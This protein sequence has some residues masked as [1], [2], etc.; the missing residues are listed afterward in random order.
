LPV[1]EQQFCLLRRIGLLLILVDQC[2]PSIL[3]WLIYVK[4]DIDQNKR[5]GVVKLP[6]LW[7]DMLHRQQMPERQI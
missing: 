6:R 7:Q 2:Q 3:C 5:Y 1:I 4:F